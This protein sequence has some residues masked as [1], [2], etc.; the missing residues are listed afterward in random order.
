MRA[1]KAIAY[2]H[3]ADRRTRTDRIENQKG[4]VVADT[5]IKGNI[6][7][8]ASQIVK[9]HPAPFPEQLANDHIISWSNP[10]DVV[11]DPFIGSGTTAKMAMLNN[12]KFI[13][14]EISE[15]YC[16]IIKERLEN[17]ERN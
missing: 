1:K 13:G 17:V 16:E 2:Q 3:E 6:W 15:N 14:V 7:V 4:H 8:Y 5:K 12:R 11:F 9:G 10:E